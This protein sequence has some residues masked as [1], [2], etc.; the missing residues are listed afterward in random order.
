MQ[1]D[2]GRSGAHAVR[3]RERAAP[4]GWH[5]RA[6]H[7]RED[8][9]RITVGDRQD[10]NLGE[11]GDVLEIQ[12]LRVLG[13]AD[14]GRQ[15][16]TGVDLHLHDTAALHALGRAHR[17]LGE[18]GSYGVTIVARV[19]VNQTSDRAVLRRN[20]GLDAAP[21]SA[22][23]RDDDRAFHAYAVP[24]EHLVV[25]GDA[26]IH[27]DDRRGDIAVDRVDVVRRQLLRLLR[28]CRVARDRGFMERETEVRGRHHLDGPLERRRIQHVERFDLRI[29]S[30]RLELR[31]EPFGV[32]LVIGRA[33]VMRAGAQALE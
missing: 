17:A 32:V 7:R 1:V 18:D 28:G 5:D 6:F 21:G 15:R 29:E 11:D 26:V 16:V 33:D 22:V 2:L 14:A 8:W 20:L 31:E 25:R 13:G 4:F 23:A 3:D 9:L 27:I 12:P 30:I 24:G 19:G 10:G